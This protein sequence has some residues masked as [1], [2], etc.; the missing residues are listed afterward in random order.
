M[1]SFAKLTLPIC[2]HFAVS[3]CLV[4]LARCGQQSMDNV[5]IG[6]V[7]AAIVAGTA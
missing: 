5:G 6:E 1:A 3:L 2:L 7:M 4:L